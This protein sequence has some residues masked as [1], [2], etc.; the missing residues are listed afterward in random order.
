LAVI[1][2]FSSTAVHRNAV[3]EMSVFLRLH[4]PLVI[5]SFQ[6][7]HYIMLARSL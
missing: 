5:F 3:Q 7:N 1:L 6:K 2:V 4:T